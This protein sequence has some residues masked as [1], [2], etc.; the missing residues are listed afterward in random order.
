[1]QSVEV[2]VFHLTCTCKLQSIFGQSL[3]HTNLTYP[4]HANVTHKPHH[5][6]L[7]SLHHITVLQASQLIAQGH[8]QQA[9]LLL[10]ISRALLSELQAL[11]QLASAALQQTS[12]ADAASLKATGQVQELQAIESYLANL[13]TQLDTTAGWGLIN[14]VQCRVYFGLI[15]L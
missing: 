13:A 3:P 4:Y 14:T 5:I 9:A 11:E 15:E 8:V 12:L 6:T 1:M 2:G 7:L 10:N